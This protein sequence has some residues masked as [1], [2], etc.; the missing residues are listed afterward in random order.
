MNTS[1][2]RA[3]QIPYLSSQSEKPLRFAPIT[4][5]LNIRKRTPERILRDLAPK[6]F[7]EVVDGLCGRTIR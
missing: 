3:L 6:S 5:E 1:A 7:R 4:E 2:A